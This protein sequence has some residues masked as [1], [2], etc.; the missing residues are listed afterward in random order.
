[1]QVPRGYPCLFCI[2]IV[3]FFVQNPSWS[4]QLRCELRRGRRG[5]SDLLSLCPTSSG[6]ALGVSFRGQ[7]EVKSR[8]PVSACRL[9]S[10]LLT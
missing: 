1:M 5:G 3:R 6:E 4:T 9:L 8:L 10:L 7:F 2:L